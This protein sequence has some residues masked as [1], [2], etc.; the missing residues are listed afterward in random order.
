MPGA[1]AIVYGAGPIGL[2]AVLLLKIAGA[3]MIIAVDVV[4]ERLEIAR[5][6]GADYVFNLKNEDR[7][8]EVILE[9]TSGW[10]ADLQIEAAGAARHT[11]PIIQKLYAKRGKVVYLGRAEALASLEL[12]NMV[13]GA[14]S[15]VGSRGH[16]GYGIFSNIIRLLQGGRLAGVQEI[17]TASF[18]FSEIMKAFAIS[19]KRTDGKILVQIG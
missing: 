15:L 5:K 6:L 9:I 4:N 16:S 8:E 7:V 3:A 19:T 10:G 13:S 18:P 11:L 17:I 1:N 12:N 2:G 14:I